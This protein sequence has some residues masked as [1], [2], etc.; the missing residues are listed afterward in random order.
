MKLSKIKKG[1]PQGEITPETFKLDKHQLSG[2][3]VVS[4]KRYPGEREAFAIGDPR[5][6]VWYAEHAYRAIT[7]YGAMRFTS[8]IDAWSEFARL[9]GRSCVK[10]FKVS[11]RWGATAD[12]DG[13]GFTKEQ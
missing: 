5:T 11:V 6:G 13:H 1:L 10:R 9:T 8:L 2:L 4:V 7:P 12:H 3:S